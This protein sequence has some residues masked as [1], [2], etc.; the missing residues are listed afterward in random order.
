MDIKTQELQDFLQQKLASY[1]FKKI[2]INVADVADAII[3]RRQ[4]WNTNRAVLMIQ[5]DKKAGSGKDYINKLKKLAGRFV[6]YIFF[7]YP[8][9]L[10]V[11]IYGDEIIDNFC[12]L[13]GLVDKLDTQTVLLQSIFIVDLKKN[14]SKHTR[15]WGQYI[16]GKFQ[17]AI[18]E[19]ISEFL[20]QLGRKKSKE[21]HL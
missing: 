4:T 5:Y 21:F 8:L 20:V 15:T 16:S 1:N 12:D 7:F 6:R 2:S 18:A 9:G 10:Q 13:E 11:I 17:D 19:S 14:E 3:W